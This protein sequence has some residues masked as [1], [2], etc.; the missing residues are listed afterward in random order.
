MKVDSLTLS[1]ALRKLFR[2]IKVT[3]FSVLTEM[4]R[5]NAEGKTEKLTPSEVL[6]IYCKNASDSGDLSFG[7]GIG[8][9]RWKELFDAVLF[10]AVELEK[11]STLEE[12]VDRDALMLV[13]AMI[14]RT[15]GDIGGRDQ[16]KLF[17]EIAYDFLEAIRS[18]ASKRNTTA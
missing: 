11:K 8:I 2:A 16:A 5:T 14:S 6:E 10:F 9:T 12:E 17:A 3:D 7:S 18:E 13:Q 4:G 15:T 1:S